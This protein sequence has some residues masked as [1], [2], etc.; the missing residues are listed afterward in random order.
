MTF[1]SRRARLVRGFE[2]F[3]LVRFQ[4]YGKRGNRLVDVLWQCRSKNRRHDSC[5]MQNPGQRNLGR[6]CIPHLGDLVCSLKD[7]L[8]ALSMVVAMCI[9]IAFRACCRIRVLPTVCA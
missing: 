4:F 8:V 6:R 5:L 7:R 9:R 2:R 1:E 3:D